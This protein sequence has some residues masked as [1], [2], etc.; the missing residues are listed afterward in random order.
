MKWEGYELSQN[1]FELK[2]HTA[3]SAWFSP[4]IGSTTWTHPTPQ[5]LVSTHPHLCSLSA[6]PPALLYPYCLL[7][8][9]CVRILYWA[10]GPSV[11]KDFKSSS[12]LVRADRD[13]I[14]PDASRLRAGFVLPCRMALLS[15]PLPT[16]HRQYL[17]IQAGAGGPAALA[18]TPKPG[19]SQSFRSL[20]PEEAYPA[21]GRREWC[22]Y[23]AAFER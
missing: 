12:A 2:R 11:I 7:Q 14:S 17:L 1:T 20:S 21:C 10:C 3:A 18:A 9:R 5:S 19:Q 23:S 8:Y 13:F 6:V 4:F 15:L 22:Q 16:P